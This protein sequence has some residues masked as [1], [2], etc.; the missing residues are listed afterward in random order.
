[1]F[2]SIVA[3]ALFYLLFDP[4]RFPRP[5]AEVYQHLL[6]LPL[7]ILLEADCD[8]IGQ[9]KEFGLRFR[10][11]L[12]AFRAER[13]REQVQMSVLDAD[14]QLSVKLILSGV[15]TVEL[16]INLRHRALAWRGWI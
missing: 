14:C 8:V 12:H 9:H 10:V 5:T 7:L 2:L 4:L 1:M 11:K 6:D 16:R 3:S 15:S 13:R